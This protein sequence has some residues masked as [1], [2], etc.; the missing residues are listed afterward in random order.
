MKEKVKKLHEEVL[1]KMDE[2]VELWLNYMEQE[3]T[4]PMNGYNVELNTGVVGPLSE[5]YYKDRDIVFVDMDG[6]TTSL[7]EEGFN[8]ETSRDLEFVVFGN[9]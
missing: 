7:M 3:G 1:Q 5:M 8:M 6:N 9:N 4:V 2:L